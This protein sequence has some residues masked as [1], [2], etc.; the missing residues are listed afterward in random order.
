MVVAP[1]A[2]G[3]T[4]GDLGG[5]SQAAERFLSTT[6]APEGSNRTAELITAYERCVKVH[7]HVRYTCIAPSA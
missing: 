1:I 7:L 3:F 2:A 6:V 4:L 5:P